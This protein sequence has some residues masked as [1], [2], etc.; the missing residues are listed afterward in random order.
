MTDVRETAKVVRTKLRLEL[1][2]AVAD[3]RAIP[4]GSLV[5]DQRASRRRLADP[6]M[7][8]PSASTVIVLFWRRHAVIS[9][10]GGGIKLSLPAQRECRRW[11]SRSSAGIS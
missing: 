9:H 3:C 4:A 10:G 5:D 11:I 7:L 8:R 2:S 6:S 1:L